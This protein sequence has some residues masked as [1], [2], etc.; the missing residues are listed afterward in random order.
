MAM[1]YSVKLA[2]AHLTLL[3][4]DSYPAMGPA[5]NVGVTMQY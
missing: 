4:D 1:A 5:M 3:D 2:L